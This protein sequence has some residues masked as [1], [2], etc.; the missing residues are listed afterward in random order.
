MVRVALTAEGARRIADLFPRFNAE[1]RA[2]TAHL[3]PAEQDAIAAM[4]RGM[5]RSV[6]GSVDDRLEAE[7]PRRVG[8]AE[9]G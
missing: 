5:L 4:L 2:I 3:T 8:R 7:G 6:G 9:P 1:E